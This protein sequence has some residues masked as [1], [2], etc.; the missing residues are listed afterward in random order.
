[1]ATFRENFFAELDAGARWSVPVA[2]NRNNPLPLD[3]NSVFRSEADLDAYLAGPLVYPGQVIALVEADKT[4]IYYIDQ[5]GAKQEVGAS[6]AADGKTV[7]IDNGTITLANMP[8]DTT[9]TYN[10]TLVNGVLTW[11]EPSA[12]TVEGLD[13]RLTAAEGQIN[14]LNQQVAELGKAFEFKGT[15]A[16]ISTDGKTIYDADGRAIEASIGDVYQIAD[17]EYAYN[18][19]LWVELGFNVDLSGYAT[20]EELEAV[21]TKAT[22]AGT[23]AANAQT[24]ANE[25]KTAA[26]NAATAAQ[27]AQETADQAVEDAEA[28]AQKAQ[29]GIDNAATAQAAAEA[30]QITANTAKSNAETNATAIGSLQTVVNGQGEKITALE[31]AKGDHATRISNL[32]TEAAKIAG[33]QESVNKNAGDISKLSTDLSTAQGTITSHGESI[34]AILGKNTEQDNAIAGIKATADAAAKQ[35]DL[36]AEIERAGTAEKANADAIKAISDDYLKGADKTELA[37]AIKAIND[38][39]LKSSDKEALTA[40]INAKAD[41]TALEA[42]VTRATEA[43]AANKALIDKLTED[44]GNVTNIMNFRGV[45]ENT[46]AGFEED[47]KALTDPKDG[48]V[49]IYKE[50]EYVYNNGVWV[51]FGD[52]GADAAAISALTNRVAANETAILAI[53]N[54]DTGILAQAK[55][56]TTAQITA[57]DLAN[58]YEQKG[59]AADALTE[60]KGYTD[61]L[62]AALKVKD[63]DNTTLQLSDTGVASVKAISTDLLVQGELELILNGGSAN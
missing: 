59:A 41:Q 34:T 50:Q 1:M 18:G 35:T 45:V 62:I 48:D 22:N 14:T 16:S 2:I 9:K 61:G 15:A 54:A 28:A 37:N 13:T 58:T 31:T 56:N 25:A 20:D 57:L 60:A 36:E 42:E 12:T 27:T 51:L 17:K 44:V 26:G 6:L 30:A 11:T 47:I 5:E 10:A 21:D 55:A 40:L 63:V 32:E 8:T 23:A 43:E 29:T 19:E 46:E 33:I 3:D 38:D 24:T 7:V 49:I 4:T 39:Y 53:N 52:A